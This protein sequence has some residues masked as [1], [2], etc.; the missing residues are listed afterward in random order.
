MGLRW[1]VSVFTCS[2]AIFSLKFC[3]RTYTLLLA[4][5]EVPKCKTDVIVVLSTPASFFLFQGF[6]V[7]P[8]PKAPRHF[9]HQHLP[10]ASR[11]G[12]CGRGGP[13]PW[14]PFFSCLSGQASFQVQYLECFLSLLNLS[15]CQTD[16]KGVCWGCLQDTD[17]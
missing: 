11:K 7:P 15:S 8:P 9:V 10:C 3:K 16:I 17:T 5:G 14:S 2:V 4:E 13:T 1:V 6:P 12:P